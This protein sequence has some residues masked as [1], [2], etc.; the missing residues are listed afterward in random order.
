M[1]KW[2]IPFD[3]YGPS[4]EKSSPPLTT[5]RNTLPPSLKSQYDEIYDAILQS[6]LT[7]K[8]IADII[9]LYTLSVGYKTD[10][11]LRYFTYSCYNGDCPTAITYKDCAPDFQNAILD[12]SFRGR[13][14]IRFKIHRKSDEMWLGVVGDPKYL[15][16]ED[17]VA[18]GVKGQWAF[19]CGRSRERYHLIEARKTVSRAQMLGGFKPE[20]NCDGIIDGGYGSFH[21]PERFLHRLVPCNTGDI[22]DLE[23]DAQEKTFS[24]IVNGVFQ[25]S[26]KAPDLPNQLAFF[27]QLDEAD[28]H[29]EFEIL[30]FKFEKKKMKGTTK[31]RSQNILSDC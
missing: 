4:E 10:F 19:Y 13:C 11:R 9:A 22:V 21:F 17:S 14:V 12:F 31:Q 18:R 24:V 30:D 6:R 23:V 20:L 27:V 15:K 29:V 5:G 8:E 26:T 2:L 28:D 1:L 3:F 25:A 16:E 7:I